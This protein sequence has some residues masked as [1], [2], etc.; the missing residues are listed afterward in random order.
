[1]GAI[2]GLFT[3]GSSLYVWAGLAVAA[4]LAIGKIVRWWNLPKV[5]EARKERAE[6]RQKERTKRAEL[7]AQR[8]EAARQAKLKSKLEENAKK[9]ESSKRAKRKE[10]N[11]GE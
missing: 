1:M 5:A 7:K 6:T 8:K 4:L 9:R 2:L 10:Q 11:K 3:G